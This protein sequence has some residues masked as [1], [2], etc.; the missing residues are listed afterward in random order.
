MVLFLNFLGKMLISVAEDLIQFYDKSCMIC[1]CV[2]E[3]KAVCPQSNLWAKFF[4]LMC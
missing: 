4:K 1:L 2:K 3:I